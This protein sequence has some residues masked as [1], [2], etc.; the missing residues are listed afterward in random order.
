MRG[1]SSCGSD[2]GVGIWRWRRR[3]RW[4]R[5]WR[6]KQSKA[7]MSQAMRRWRSRKRMQQVGRRLRTKGHRS[8]SQHTIELLPGTCLSSTRRR[9]EVWHSR[10]ERRKWKRTQIQSTAYEC[11]AQQ[12]GRLCSGYR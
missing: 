1:I 12:W 9:G 11:N 8:Y 5:R 7:R 6:R 10:R 2:G 3:R 4:R